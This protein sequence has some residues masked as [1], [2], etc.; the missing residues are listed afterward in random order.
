[1]AE[2]ILTLD[3][4][5]VYVITLEQ[6]HSMSMTQ[7]KEM[8]NSLGIE[9]TEVTPVRSKL[10]Q[11]IKDCL[12]RHDAIFEDKVIDSDETVVLKVSETLNT[13][14]ASHDLKVN[15]QGLG[16][17]Y[18]FKLEM[19]RLEL[20]VE[21]ERIASNEKIELAKARTPNRIFNHV[22]FS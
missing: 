4:L 19:K 9:I 1:M 7:L 22:V 21:R 11:E 13:D 5:N 20:L 2:A 12:K 17:E 10:I 6:L 15:E 16:E 3:Q 14:K 18:R 8:A